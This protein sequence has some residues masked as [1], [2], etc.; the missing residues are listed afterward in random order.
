MTKLK[1]HSRYKNVNTFYIAIDEN[2][3]VVTSN[4][5]YVRCILS[6]DGGND[7]LS[8]VDFEG[9]P[10]LSVG[11]LFYDTGK[12]IKSIKSAYYVELE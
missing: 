8:A 1:L 5:N 9:G 11:N 2:H 7:K 3:G 10:M 4:G 12:R 6:S